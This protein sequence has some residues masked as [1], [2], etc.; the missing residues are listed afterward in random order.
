MGRER[1]IPKEITIRVQLPSEASQVLKDIHDDRQ[2]VGWGAVI[3]TGFLVL[4]V[5]MRLFRRG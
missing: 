3:V 2:A 5:A 4:L 1:I